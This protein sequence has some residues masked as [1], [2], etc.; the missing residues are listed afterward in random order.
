[1]TD[2]LTRAWNLLTPE[3]RPEGM[4]RIVVPHSNPIQ[5]AYYD[6]TYTPNNL[7]PAA[8]R[9]RLIVACEGVLLADGC[10]H[11]QGAEKHYWT[12]ID[13]N[14]IAGHPDRLTAAVAALEAE[15]SRP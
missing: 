7:S 9:D 14:K 10:T 1:M 6:D 2:V 5:Y 13:G 12:N 3:E 8:A 11:D 15:R 4:R